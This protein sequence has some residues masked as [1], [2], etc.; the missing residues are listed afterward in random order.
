[1]R[2]RVAVSRKAREAARGYRL[3]DVTAGASGKTGDSE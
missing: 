3:D 2:V 1:M